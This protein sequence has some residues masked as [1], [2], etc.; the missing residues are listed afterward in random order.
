[1]LAADASGDKRL[2]KSARHFAELVAAGATPTVSGTEASSSRKTVLVNA[3]AQI[4]GLPPLVGWLLVG[5]GSQATLVES[6]RNVARTYQQRVESLDD[7]LRFYLPLYLIVVIGGTAV[8][9]NAL[10]LLGPWYQ[11]LSH[12]GDALK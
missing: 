9:F 11:M 1:V 8:V 7:W 12:F 10:S 6:L 2:G 3:P 4:A 5:G